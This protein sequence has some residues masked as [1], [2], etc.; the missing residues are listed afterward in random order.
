MARRRTREGR[1]LKLMGERSRSEHALDGVRRLK[2]YQVLAGLRWWAMRMNWKPG[3]ASVCYREIYGDWP[4]WDL[5]PSPVEPPEALMEWI[6]LRK[7]RTKSKPGPKRA[8]ASSANV[9]LEKEY[10]VLLT[11]EDVSPLM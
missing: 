9:I 3:W 10:D 1:L 2:Q 8:R 7:R 4:P 6:A 11:S 5:K